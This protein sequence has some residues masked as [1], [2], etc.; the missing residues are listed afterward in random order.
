MLRKLCTLV[1]LDPRSSASIEIH[2]K[3]EKSRGVWTNIYMQFHIIRILSK[4]NNR[5]THWGL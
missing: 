3:S 1:P 2:F 4:F 5:T